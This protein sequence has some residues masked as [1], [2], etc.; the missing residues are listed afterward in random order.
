MQKLHLYL[1]LS[2]ILGISACSPS[3][4]LARQYS[5]KKQNLEE[6]IFKKD[7]NGVDQ[8]SYDK[9]KYLVSKRQITKLGD[10]QELYEQLRTYNEAEFY[11]PFLEGEKVYYL[12]KTKAEK[13]EY[14]RFQSMQVR[15][16]FG[17]GEV[18][19]QLSLDTL[20]ALCT[21]T[22]RTLKVAVSSYEGLLKLNLG[23]VYEH[24]L[25]SA[26][27]LVPEV[28]EHLKNAPLYAIHQ[29]DKATFASINSVELVQKIAEVELH[30]HIYYMQIELK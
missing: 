25:M 28:I 23:K 30:D 22:E 12:R 19:F 29:S 27:K 26:D 21:E 16:E 14:V 3:Q 10:D 6:A 20:K 7:E 4:K 13:K 8:L 1:I 15:Q 24:P 2:L 9:E 11:G 17:L 5:L 18:D